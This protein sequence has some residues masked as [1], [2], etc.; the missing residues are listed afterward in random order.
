MTLTVSIL[1]ILSLFYILGYRVDLRQHTV[2]QTG[3]VQFLTTP[4]DATVEID[5]KA[6][7]S[8][9]PTKETVSLGMHEFVMWREGYE[10]WRKSLDIPS[11]IT[12]LNYTRLIPKKRTI[13][14]V[15]SIN[16]ASSNIVSPDRRFMAVLSDTSKPEISI[17]DLTPDTIALPQT[18]TFTSD[19]YTESA[20]QTGHQF[21]FFKWDD[22]GRFLL[23][24]HQFASISEL[25]VFDRQT[26]KIRSN[27][28]RTMDVQIQDIVA[29]DT[30]GDRYLVLVNNDVRKL[31]LGAET[32]SKPLV[33]DVSSFSFDSSSGAVA[34]VE[35]PELST[36]YRKVG[37]VRKDG[38]PVVMYRSD[39]RTDVPLLIRAARYFAQDYVTIAE[40]N[41]VTIYSGDFPANENDSMKRYAQFEAPGNLSALHVSPSGRFII[42]QFGSQFVGYDIERKKLSPVAQLP[43]GASPLRWFDD[44]MLYYEHKGILTVRE[45]DGANIHDLHT[46]APGFSVTLSQN[47]KYLYSIG[48]A[49]GGHLRLQRLRMILN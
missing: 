7:S 41:K 23:V 36:G 21:S 15:R 20:Q 5:G 49:D 29:M 31:D 16:M 37:I 34:Y 47:G 3:V 2:E 6:L 18:Y 22:V 24:R 27:I 17:F 39:V 40:G 26:G 33:S 43:E 25:L 30:S 19:S 11:T 14:T 8:R 48:R 1:V 4:S 46:V 13:E 28:S 44:F 42:A 12:W 10:T 32:L 38:K 9:T 45:F 35:L